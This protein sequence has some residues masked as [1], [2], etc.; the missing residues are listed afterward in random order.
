MSMLRLY[1]KAI[2]QKM[3]DYWLRLE[4][5]L[6]YENAEHMVNCI[7]SGQIAQGFIYFLNR[8]FRVLD[9]T[10][11]NSNH[12]CIATHKDWQHFLDVLLDMP[13]LLPQINI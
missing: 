10:S 13:S 1:N 4:F 3:E 7:L 2:E 11:T 5:Q 12:S 9:F 8:Y 6:K